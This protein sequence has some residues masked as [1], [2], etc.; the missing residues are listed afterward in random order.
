M[1]TVDQHI[2]QSIRAKAA[3]REG[4]DRE[5][6]VWFLTQDDTATIDE[7]A[8]TANAMRARLLGKQACIHGIIEMS[9]ICRRNCLYCG[10]RSSNA[11]LPRYRLEE[12]QIIDL[13]VSAVK[14]LGYKMLVLQSGE[15]LHFTTEQMIRIVQTINKTSGALVFLSVGERDR[16]F[17]QK[18]WIAGARGVLFRFE[19]TDPKIYEEMRPT[20][21]YADR[22]EHL[23][24]LKEA[25]YIMATGPLIG[26]PGQTME[27]L[28]DDLL[29]IRDS[30][31]F[32]VSMGPLIAHPDTPLAGAPAVSSTLVRKMIVAA[33]LVMP[34]ARIPI[35][36]AMEY[37]WG[38]DFR[39]LALRSGANSF[40]L[41]LTPAEVRDSY[42]VYPNKNKL[43]E[44]L[45]TPTAFSQVNG[46][47]EEC[48]MK[49]CL[50]FGA[51]LALSSEEFAIGCSMPQ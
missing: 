7:L 39:R 9:N 31:A 16:I 18:M 32:M 49:L 47:I 25:G 12:Q 45:H 38:D 42:D 13:A 41:N 35:T 11:A 29:L 44:H 15:D 5:E 8:D 21:D 40:M 51:D 6:A 10:L 26:L 30:G 22:M 14:K 48:G 46:I 23:K 28:A 36:T 27:T 24:F 37:L 1:G 50:G 17:Y 3:R 19:T 20:A 2:L 4:I 33:R 43:A 34:R